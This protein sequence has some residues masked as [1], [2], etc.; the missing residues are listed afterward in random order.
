MSRKIV[1][2]F[3]KKAVMFAMAG[4]MAFSGASGQPVLRMQI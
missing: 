4:T 1:K 3:K 2:N